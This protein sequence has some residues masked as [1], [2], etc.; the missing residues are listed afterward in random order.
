MANKKISQLTSMGTVGIGSEDYF[1]TSESLGG[2]NYA[3]VKSTALQVSEYVLNPISATQISG[4]NKNIYFDNNDNWVDASNQS[5][6]S[7]PFLQ[8]RKSD[9]LLVTGSGIAFDT[10]SV[11]WNYKAAQ[12]IQMQGQN[13]T[14]AG[15][16]GFGNSNAIG[17][18]DRSRIYN[19]DGN[20]TDLQLL[21]YQDLIVSGNRN[22]LLKAQGIDASLTPFVGE[23]KVTGGNLDIDPDYSLRVNEIQGVQGS[24]ANDDASISINGASRHVPAQYAVASNNYTTINWRDSNIQYGTVTNGSQTA[25]NV[26]FFNT[27]A[28]TWDSSL[29]DGQTLTFY[30]KN[31]TSATLSPTFKLDGAVGDVEWGDQYY[32]N[33]PSLYGSQTSVYT[34]LKIGTKVFG[35][36]IT[37]YAI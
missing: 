21:G 14:G 15:N 19:S 17:G 18:L 12:D 11:P 10:T 2:G 31:N 3:T 9:G 13:I 7:F 8:V 1:V 22:I 25:F 26:D 30:L 34:F 35:S 23:V 33:G 32:P 16:I 4:D 29:S 6:E 5:V 37:G 20:G 36:A 28:N 24:A 27:A